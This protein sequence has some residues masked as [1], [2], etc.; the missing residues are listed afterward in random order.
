[1]FLLRRLTFI[2]IILAATIAS[3]GDKSSDKLEGWMPI[4]E[5][6]RQ[7]KDIPGNPGAP[8]IQLYYSYYKDED[9]G[10]LFVYRR[11]KILRDSGKKYADAEIELGPQFS[12]SRFQASLRELKAR[13]IHP[14][15]SIVEFKDKVFEK[16]VYKRR[17]V[18]IAVKAFTFPEVTIGSIVEYHCTLLLPFHIVSIVSEWPIQS[19]LYT[20]KG[21]FRFR[22]A[23]T[24]VDVP[25]MWESGFA[26]SQVAYTYLN[27]VDVTVPQKKSNN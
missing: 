12:F 25:T 11:I 2:A 13:T 22:A 23:Q 8:A 1:M 14:D 6:D 5:Q 4:T 24:V 9:A 19:D 27:Q 15:G 10:F 16:T 18:K 3:A 20:V 7:V 26:H 21:R 17:G